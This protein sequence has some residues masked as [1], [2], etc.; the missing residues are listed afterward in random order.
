L[1]G[2]GG[3][4]DEVAGAALPLVEEPVGVSVKE[5][6]TAKTPQPKEEAAKVEAQATRTEHSAYQVKLEKDWG[7][8]EKLA[9]RRQVAL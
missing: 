8:G 5:I 4:K 7:G 3:R 9:G 6:E 1:S 2:G